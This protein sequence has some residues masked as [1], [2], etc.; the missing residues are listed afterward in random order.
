MVPLQ[1]TAN[2]ARLETEEVERGLKRVSWERL[3]PNEKTL[4]KVARYE[5]TSPEGFTEPSTSSKHSIPGV[6]AVLLP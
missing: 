6:R 1:R 2:Q 5:A 4:E 3:L